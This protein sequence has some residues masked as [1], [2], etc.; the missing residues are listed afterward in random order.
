MISPFPQHKKVDRLVY[1]RDMQCFIQAKVNHHF[2]RR[3]MNRVGKQIDENILSVCLL[4][5]N[6]EPCFKK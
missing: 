2:M 5:A 4:E 6:K 1:T 3:Y